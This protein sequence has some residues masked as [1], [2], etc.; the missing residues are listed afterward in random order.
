VGVPPGVQW[1]FNHDPA[2]A[3]ERKRNAS[4]AGKS[5]PN[6]ELSDI[7]TVLYKLTCRVLSSDI[8]PG[9]AS[10]ANQLT[11]TRLR[12]IDLERRIRDQEELEARIGELERDAEQRKGGQSWG[13]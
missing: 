11:N 9:P 13:A 7:K 4:R 3:D 6:R 5:R 10:V 8:P 1:C 2:R 12:A